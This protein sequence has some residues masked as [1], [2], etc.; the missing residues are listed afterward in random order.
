MSLSCGSGS[1]YQEESL[2][3]SVDLLLPFLEFRPETYVLCKAEAL[4]DY[5]EQLLFFKLQSAKAIGDH[6]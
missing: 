3:V 6:F 4:S 5:T 2:T 1:E